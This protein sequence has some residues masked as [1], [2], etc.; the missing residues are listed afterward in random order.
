VQNPATAVVDNA[1]FAAEQERARAEAQAAQA[2]RDAKLAGG[3][4]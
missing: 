2:V 4:N 3:T 1:V